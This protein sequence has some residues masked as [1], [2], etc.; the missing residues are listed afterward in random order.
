MWLVF[1][2]SVDAISWWQLEQHKALSWK[3]C[4]NVIPLAVTLWFYFVSCVSVISSVMC[5]RFNSVMPDDAYTS[6]RAKLS[7]H[8]VLS[9]QKAI[10]WYCDYWYSPKGNFNE[11]APQD[12]IHRIM[13]LERV[14]VQI[15]CQLFWE[16]I[17]AFAAV[18]FYLYICDPDLKHLV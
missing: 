4:I 7:L 14:L 18:F 2:V 8:Q 16:I 3:P 17:G 12:I 13:H 9:C 15:Q 6:S 10:N 5:L 1:H 11:I